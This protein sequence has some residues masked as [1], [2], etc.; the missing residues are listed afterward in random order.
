MIFINDLPCWSVVLVNQDRRL[1]SRSHLSLTLPSLPVPRCLF[2]ARTGRSAH[3]YVMHV[4]ERGLFTMSTGMMGENVVEWLLKDQIY[5][6]RGR[7]LQ[8]SFEDSKH[9][10]C[11]TVVFCLLACSL[12]DRL[13]VFLWYALLGSEI[14]RVG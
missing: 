14:I 13:R 8:A 10:H 12:V 6:M 3:S 4:G 7:R 2:I 5:Q 9:S 11:G 1:G